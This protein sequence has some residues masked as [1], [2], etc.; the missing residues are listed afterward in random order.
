MRW[1]TPPRSPRAHA[2]TSRGPWPPVAGYRGVAFLGAQDVEARQA[3]S[4]M[5]IPCR[6]IAYYM[7]TTEAGQQPLLVY[8]TKDGLIT[9][10][11]D[12]VN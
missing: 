3:S 9:D 8:V 10:F 6:R 12:V 5:D 1:P 4:V 7:L 11:D 2:A